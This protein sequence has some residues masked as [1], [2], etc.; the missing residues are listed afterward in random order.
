ME[1]EYHL[2]HSLLAAQAFLATLRASGASYSAS[3]FSRSKPGNPLY[4]VVVY[5]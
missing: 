2:F 3:R 1:A 4:K 5:G